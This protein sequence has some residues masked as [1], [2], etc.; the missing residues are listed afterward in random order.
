[1]KKIKQ[2]FKKF[3]KVSL[4]KKAI[5]IVGLAAVLTPAAMAVWGP[6]R[7]VFDYNDPTGRLGSM[8]GPV[9][10]SMKNTPTYGDE[11]NFTTARKV[12]D[13]TWSN[14]LKVK[15]GD[16]VEIRVYIHNNANT[17]T[18]ASGLGIA[19]NVKAGVDVPLNQYGTKNEP[20]GFVNAS[21]S[22]PKEVFDST[23]I[24]SADG[25]KFKLEQVKGSSILTQRDNSTTVKA[26]LS[27]SFV[28]FNGTAV[29][30]Q[31]GG[32]TD[33]NWLGC[34][35][36]V[37]WV[38]TKVKVIA[39]PKP[40]TPNFTIKKYV[41]GEDAQDNN[42][43]VKVKAGEQFEYKVDV[44]NTGDT[45]L[46]NV[47]AWDTLPTGVSYVDN[48]L[49]LEGTT[50]SNDEDFFNAN[51]GVNIPSIAKGAK[52]TFTFKA[53][54]PAKDSAEKEK[55]CKPGVGTFY[56][57][58]AKAD[59][60]G[61]LPTKEDPAVVNCDYTPPKNTPAIEVEKKVS[62][63]V[64]KV[65][66]PFIY[67]VK[68]TNTGNVDLKN[69]KVDDPAPANIT[70]DSVAQTAGIAFTFSP[71]R[72]QAVIASLKVGESTS[73]NITARV[74]KYVS[75][76]IINT[77][78]VNA[79]EVNPEQP[80]KNDDCAEVPVTTVEFCPIPGKENLP[81]NDMNCNTPTV[82]PSTGT[83]PL[84]AVISAIL[85]G[86]IAFLTNKKMSSA[87]EVRAK[88]SSKKK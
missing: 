59:P 30:S 76:Q 23:L 32:A 78:C 24:S 28:S 16:E 57:N 7:P 63:P 42:T 19:R 88:A 51:K 53:V 37:G 67:T 34:Y 38:I 12:G 71:S 49:K 65:N 31:P 58:I 48:T 1:M 44:T 6:N 3:K 45:E 74:T 29:G 33:G 26:T 8:T 2:F 69:V 47:K 41:N 11:F 82:I 80:E 87:K 21:N 55:A 64:V 50:V 62:A 79:P 43:A 72:V 10:N 40:E 56:N 83:G 20:I 70:F 66:E 68:V 84:L 15:D 73:F 86:T 85:V 52:K 54:I 13:A 35:E 36:H 18:N 25:T 81:K 5:L 60:E 14:D 77:V 75:G 46:K 4:A 22:A 27:D 9:F 17:G 39:E 61:S